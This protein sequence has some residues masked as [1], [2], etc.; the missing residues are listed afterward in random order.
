MYLNWERDEVYLAKFNETSTQTEHSTS[1]EWITSVE[2]E[3]T[4]ETVTASAAS[5][6]KRD[7][8]AAEI[9]AGTLDGGASVIPGTSIISAVGIVAPAATAS[10]RST[11]ITIERARRAAKIPYEVDCKLCLSLLNRTMHQE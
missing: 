4:I 11:S 9:D 5:T 1:T 3:T 10:G 2:T 7:V 6:K 8:G